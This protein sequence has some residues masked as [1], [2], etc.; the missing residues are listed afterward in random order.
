MLDGRVLEASQV[1]YEPF[2][3]TPLKRELLSYY[4]TAQVDGL[5]ANK[6]GVTEAASALQR[7]S[8]FTCI[9]LVWGPELDLAAVELARA[10]RLGRKAQLAAHA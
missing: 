9:C 6:L 4:T 3:K 5:L 1:E 10:A 7:V 2:G 8:L